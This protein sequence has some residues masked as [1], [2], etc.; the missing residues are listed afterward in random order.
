MA[1]VL[2]RPLEPFEYVHHKNGHRDDNRIENLELW[3]G[4][5]KSKK[6]PKGQRM[7][8]LMNAFLSQPEVTDR[9]A[10]EVAFR[11]IFRI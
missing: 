11:R 5:A 1:K 6:D 7:E 2:G 9:A 4:H 10:V 8:D 3:A